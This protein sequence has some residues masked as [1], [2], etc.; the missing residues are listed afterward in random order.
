MPFTPR[1]WKDRPAQLAPEPDETLYEWGLRVAAY[2]VA[3]PG[4]TTPI[5]AAALEDLETRLSDYTDSELAALAATVA[6]DSELAAAIASEA[7]SRNTAISDAIT[8]LGL[9]TASTHAATDFDSA[10][11]AAAAQAASQPLDSDLTAIAALTTTAYGRAFLALADAAAGRTALGL[12]TAATAATGDF[13]T[14]GA[15][16]AAQAASQPLDSD[17]T[18]LAALTTTAF[19]RALL[20]LADA[21][22]GR[23]AL[24]LGTAA[25]LNVPASGNAAAGEVVKGSDTRLSDTRT[26]TDATVSIAKLASGVL[27]TDGTL[28]ANSDSKI[29]SEK[30]VKTYVDAEATARAAALGMPLGLT[31]ATQATR[32]VGATTSGAPATGT[33]AIG[34]F[35][36]DRANGYLW[37]CTTAGSP[38]T[39]TRVGGGTELG[40]SEITTPP[41]SL[42]GTT[43]ITDISGVTTTVTV[44]SRP[45]VVEA[46]IGWAGITAGSAPLVGNLLIREG[47]T[48]LQYARVVSVTSGQG[49]A[50]HL[51]V[52]LAPSAGSHTYKLSWNLV[53][54]ANT[55]A[56]TADPTGPVFITVRE[57]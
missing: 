55:F 7:S 57:V 25:P 22:A 37:I 15:A 31:G 39:W 51:A 42:T 56:I 19:G 4:E 3:H 21:A 24:G 40:Y 43:A 10:G 30:A 14:S 1:D 12:G 46:Y 54:S 35:V 29:P 36:I 2:E 53:N 28:A 16:A 20:E 11:A 47:S 52:R 44:G 23:T 8:A 45:I 17:L 34:D 6:T 50:S 18:A 49:V 9:G 13:D 27:D 5:T 48:T 41:S 26:P 38:G 33:F 32:Y